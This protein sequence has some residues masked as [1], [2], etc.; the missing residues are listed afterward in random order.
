MYQ[1]II[2]TAII[3]LG[4]AFI[5]SL[6]YLVRIRNA[7]EYGRKRWSKVLRTFVWGGGF[8]VIVAIILSLVLVGFI[9]IPTL[10]REYEFLQDG[11]IQSLIVVC[12]IAPLVEEFTKVL[13]VFTVRDALTDKEAGLV[14]GAACGLGFAATENLLYEGSTYMAEGL[15]AA[16]IAIVVVR[17]IS[18]TLLHG[19]ASAV[20]GYG[21]TKGKF[22][23][24]SSFFPY[25]MI[26]VFMHGA[27]NFL[28]SVNLLYGQRMS[29]L[30]LVA[31]VLFAV[32]SMRFV[33][34][35]IIKLDRGA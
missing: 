3:L 25:Y 20:A 29:L 11:T 1:E 17:S 21:I 33:R 9:S 23:G 27:F 26:A 5:P 30:S 22:E 8:A 6:I 13:G 32:L 10:Q 14:F 31:A 35:K 16:F 34:K 7:E 19:S 15:G 4:A 2:L 24:T 18:S 12:V 28:A